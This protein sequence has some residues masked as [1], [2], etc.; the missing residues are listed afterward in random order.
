MTQ[1]QLDPAPN[2]RPISES[3]KDH[4]TGIIKTLH[5]AT[6]RVNEFG[7]TIDPTP[8]EMVLYLYENRAN[9][10]P[11][12][13]LMYRT[14][15]L[16]WLST[17][18][19]DAY[20]KEAW[21]VLH[22]PLPADGYKGPKGTDTT[23][24]Y[25]SRSSRPRT[26]SRRKLN[27][28]L[29][30]LSSRM[31]NARTHVERKRAAELSYWLQAGLA[32]GLRP[33]EWSQAFWVNKD[34][35]ELSVITAKRKHG[36]YALPA[37]SHMS[38]ADA[39]PVRTIY[40]PDEQDRLWVELHLKSVRAHLSEGKPFKSYYN[41]NRL[42]LVNICSAIFPPNEP[43]ITLYMLRGQFAANRKISG[44]PSDLLS[45]EMGCSAHH[46]HRAYGKKIHGY[47]NLKGTFKH[48]DHNVNNE[49]NLNADYDSDDF[50]G[51][52]Y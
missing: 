15:L 13:F 7:Y 37:I 1:K 6:L 40:I 17:L 44:Q 43:N 36:R 42:Y 41:N 30:E 14:A 38:D 48:Q 16:W 23:T 33:T 45:D 18:P 35:G 5:K 50:T 24:I 31:D 51:D 4:Y 12:S 49:Q 26:V 20:I 19:V 46:A 8:L 10:R 3:S 28:L 2:S 27:R 47:K 52:H 34:K 32:T 21:E 11:K 25:S 29:K 22:R 9:Y 39:L